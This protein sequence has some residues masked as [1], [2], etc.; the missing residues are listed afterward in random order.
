MRFAFVLR[1]L[2]ALAALLPVASWARADALTPPEAA[3]KLGQKVTV[4]FRVKGTGANAAGYAELYSEASWRDPD[5]FFV[6]LPESTEVARYAGRL[7]SVTGEVGVLQFG[8]LQRMVIY[9]PDAARVTVLDP[10][11][12][13]TPTAAYT[14]K[15]IRGF[16]VLVHPAVVEDSLAA[17]QAFAELE[18][19]MDRITAAL[20][21]EVLASLREARIWLEWQQRDDTAA[22]FHPARAWL[23]THGY[24]PEK[25]GDVEICHVRNWVAWSRREQPESLL[26]EL[27]HAY[28]FRVLGENDPLIRHAYEQAMAAGLYD[29]VPYAGGG[30]R[31]AHAARNPAEYF[32]ELTEAY[33]GLNDFYPFTRAE[34]LRYDP[35]GYRAVEQLWT[36]RTTL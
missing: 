3:A 29:A 32:A 22:Q 23:L 5:A 8:D 30:R 19:Q 17:S 20:P 27:A 13:F 26:H 21:E 31:E 34:L 9:V 14:R 11:P 2:F 12:A 16:T 35:M 36:R 4:Q 28:H 25:A 6:R 33:F 18:S 1:R 7:I 15:T 10:L 24:N